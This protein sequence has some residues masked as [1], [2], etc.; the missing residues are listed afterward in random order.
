MSLGRFS[1][2]LVSVTTILAARPALAEE[3]GAAAIATAHP[4]RGRDVTM[5][6]I[7]FGARAGEA[8]FALNSE[9]YSAKGL[10]VDNWNDTGRQL[11][12]TFCVGGDGYFLK[13]DFPV[14]K[15]SKAS[16]YGL[17]LYP[18]NFGHLFRTTGLFP[19]LSGGVAA[20]VIT[21]PGQGISGASAQARGAVGLKVHLWGGLG[22]SAEVGYSPFVAAALVDKQK[23]HDLVQS[24]IDGQSFEVPAGSR[25]ARGGIGRGVDFLVG[26]EWL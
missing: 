21:L 8:R 6:K 12:P 4:T 15:A 10:P 26:I 3:P 9:R 11:V 7:A 23:M 16:S 17:G 25:P 14:M 24:A 1:F 19:F 20:S 5:H 18:I 2:V 22:L 13:L